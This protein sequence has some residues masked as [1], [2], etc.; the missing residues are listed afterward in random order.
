MNIHEYQAKE[1]FANFGVAVAKGAAAKDV[2][3]FEAAV[4]SLN[5]S[6]VVVKSQIH[7][8]GR[9]KGVF[10]DGFKG[11]VHYAKRIQPFNRNGQSFRQ[12]C[13]NCI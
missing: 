5:G 2:S 10:K 9:G 12:G 7:A 3:E 4:A 1:L 11:G 8:G 6:H 13:C